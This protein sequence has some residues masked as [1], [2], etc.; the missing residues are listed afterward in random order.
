MA[1]GEKIVS[2]RDA[3]KGTLKAGV[4]TAP[5]ILSVVGLPA[6]AASASPPRTTLVFVPA[7]GSPFTVG[8]VP[9]NIVVGDFNGDRKLDL[10]IAN[11]GTDNVSVLLGTGNGGFTNAPTSP[12]AV[13]RRPQGI[14]AGDFN[15][16]GKLDLAVTNSFDN[17]VS[18]LLGTGNSRFTNASGSPF[19]VGAMPIGV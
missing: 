16:D 17:T 9:F 12:I 18:V 7:P 13:G 8:R 4:Y 6:V 15:G 3:M 10:A 19:T 2:R 11:R 1:S 5:V 14:A